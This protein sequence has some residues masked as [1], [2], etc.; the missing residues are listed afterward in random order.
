MVKLAVLAQVI[1]ALSIVLVWVVRFPNVVKEFH[2][3]GLPDGVRT[4]V[5][6]TKISLATLLIAGI[7]YPAMVAIP[8]LMMAF[9]MVCA[10]GAHMKV[11]HPW[12]KYVP[13][14]LLLVLSLFVAAVHLNVVHA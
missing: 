5:G 10:Q 14:L 9:L 12:Q 2:E 8:A 4:L 7:W 11:R 3:Y 6:A 13:S 1:L